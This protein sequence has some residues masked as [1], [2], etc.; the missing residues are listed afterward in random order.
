MKFCM[1]A[2]LH[3]AT[4]DLS[5]KCQNSNLGYVNF[6]MTASFISS[7]CYG[8]TRRNDGRND[9]GKTIWVGYFTLKDDS[10]KFKYTQLKRFISLHVIK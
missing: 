10:I 1:I 6:L 8:A 9:K 7:L 3:T 4:Q 5:K 2:I